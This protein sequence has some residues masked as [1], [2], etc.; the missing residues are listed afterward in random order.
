M[1]EYQPTPDFYNDYI[2][3]H[4][5][6]GQKWGVRNGPPYP[7]NRSVSTGKSLK[8]GTQPKKKNPETS[9]T[10]YGGAKKKIFGKDNRAQDALKIANS[11]QDMFNDILDRIYIDGDN[12]DKTEYSKTL[13]KI[14]SDEGVDKNELR[15]AVENVYFKRLK[16]KTAEE[17]KKITD[18]D[19]LTGN[20][21]NEHDTRSI[22]AAK[23]GL[24]ALNKTR[25]YDDFNPDSESDQFWFLVEDQTIGLPLISDLVNQGK[26]KAEIMDMFETANKTPILAPRIYDPG[27]FEFSELYEPELPTFIDAC[28]E[29]KKAQD[30]RQSVHDQLSSIFDMMNIN[31]NEYILDEEATRKANNNLRGKRK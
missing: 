28:I 19:L 16:E 9:N 24:E 21:I 26:S 17:A 29:A 31:P 2:A 6:K 20:K 23:L 3:H 5:I 1:R 7:L 30:A 14:A 27:F 18:A 10:L 22:K 15:Q 13:D 8:K 12:Y 25:S 4:G 11:H